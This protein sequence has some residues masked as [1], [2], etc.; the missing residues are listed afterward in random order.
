MSITVTARDNTERIS[1]IVYSDKRKLADKRDDGEVEQLRSVVASLAWIARQTRPGLSYRVSRLQ[2]RVNHATVADLRE[3]NHVLQYAKDT[4]EK[5]LFYTSDGV[6]WDTAVMC[7]I[8]DASFCNE[9][10]VTANGKEEF[11]SQ[12]GYL[13]CI[14]SPNVINE[15]SAMI[16]PICWSSTTI[17]RVCRSTLMAEAYS[18]STGVEQGL[19]IRAAI[20]DAR[21]V[22]D[23]KS[24]EESAQEN[25]AHVWI[26]DCDS[27]Y[28]HLISPRNKQVDN[29][30]LAI[31]MAALRQIIW[32]RRDGEDTNLA[33]STKGDYP[34]WVDT[35]VMLSDPLTKVMAADVLEEA[36]MTGFYDMT[37]SA[38][39]LIIKE[40]NRASRKK[41]KN[42]KKGV[43]EDL[44]NAEQ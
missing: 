25:M 42:E 33:D 11:R 28:E 4:S 15:E 41:M 39:S 10:K 43:G 37:P 17:K 44:D 6:G 9:V 5:G 16:H 24:W 14:A 21:G 18:M 12:Q 31:D 19:R 1:G 2:S 29:K 23:K 26:T 8:T 27:L 35:S 32:D 34:R 7:T 13:T 40:K 38:E 3:C 22:L 36:L 30:R 20:C